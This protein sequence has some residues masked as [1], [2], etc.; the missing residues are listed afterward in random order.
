LSTN[1]AMQC[2]TLVN[3]QWQE[4]DV[5][6]LI[7]RIADIDKKIKDIRDGNKGL[8][9]IADQINKQRKN[10]QDEQEV[11]YK[12]I[13][14]HDNKLNQLKDAK[15]KLNEKQNNPPINPTPFQKSSLDERYKQAV[16]AAQIEKLQIDNLDRITTYVVQVLNNE[17]RKC[18]NGIAECEKK[19]ESIFTD[20]KRTWPADA[21][22]LDATLSSAEE[23]FEKL[24]R[25]ETDGLPT[26]EQ[27]FFELLKNQ[28]NQNLASLNAHL[29]NERKA[30]LDRMALVNDSLKQVPFNQSKTQ[31]TFLCI[32][33]NDRQLQEVREFKQDIQ[34]ALS[35]AWSEDRELAESKFVTLRKLVERLSSQD[36]E[37]KRWKE[38][39]LDVRLHVEFIGRETDENN[40][41]VEIYRSGAGKSGGQR[42]KLTTTCLAAALR[43]QLGGNDHGFPI[44]SPVILDEAFDKADNEFTALAMNIFN[45]FGFQMI[46][47]TPL[48]S[49]MTL[50]PFIGGACFVDIKDRNTSSVLH[51]KYD[52]ERQ[53]LD[54]AIARKGADNEIS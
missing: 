16:I 34:Q 25:L 4:I 6:P 42:Q 33:V 39:V 26:H 19:I 52:N 37:Y 10:I 30:I 35:Y 32:D 29:N 51:I 8:R 11:L 36:S 49:V 9:D 21:S 7:G 23:F 38:L 5:M 54:L 20:F 40:I 27:R 45:N 28:S 47:A 50:E 17:I 24:T 31:E 22:D 43:Y 44:Y 12:I 1:R 3:M 53:R 48:K 2:Q 46:V 18:E 15:D 41:E 13:G 14:K